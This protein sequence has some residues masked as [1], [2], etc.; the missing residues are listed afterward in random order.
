M[1]KHS[2]SIF[3]TKHV[4]HLFLLFG[5]VKGR[6]CKKQGRNPFL[7]SRDR[8]VK[9]WH[10]WMNQTLS[11]PWAG[12]RA[13]EDKHTSRTWDLPEQARPVQWSL[14][15]EGCKQG[16]WAAVHPVFCSKWVLIWLN[17]THP[18][19]VIPGLPQSTDSN[20]NCFEKHKQRCALADT[21]RDHIFTSHVRIL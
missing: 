14:P 18:C 1:P 4:L 10:E 5:S 16:Y 15:G 6:G 11:K 2:G 9:S 20:A 17:G 3:F 21:P 7:V 12:T 19:Q 8:H 13:A